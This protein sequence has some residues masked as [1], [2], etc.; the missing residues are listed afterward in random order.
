MSNTGKLKNFQQLLG[1][2]NS[3]K[4]GISDHPKITKPLAVK[5]ISTQ[6]ENCENQEPLSV[7]VK[8]S[9][10]TG[11]NPSHSKPFMYQPMTLGNPNSNILQPSLL[12]NP[13]F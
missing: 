12:G 1:L 8:L 3:K 4:A 13:K 10:K 9:Q 5:Q 2:L 11:S 7:N 6:N